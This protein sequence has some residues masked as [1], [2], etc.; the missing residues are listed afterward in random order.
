M[1]NQSTSTLMDNQSTYNT[2]R[3]GQIDLR[4]LFLENKVDF[5][6]K[7]M[8]S[9]DEMRI[10]LDEIHEMMKETKT[11]ALKTSFYLKL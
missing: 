11:S 6:C 9:L 8:D 7:K 1:D 5:L 10:K 4:L 2:V 3:A